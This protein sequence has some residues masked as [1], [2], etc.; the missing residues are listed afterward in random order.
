MSSGHGLD[1][2]APAEIASANLRVIRGL[3]DDDGVARDAALDLVWFDRAA[4]WAMIGTL[5]DAC[6]TD[7]ELCR[8]GAG[9]LEDLL[10][11]DEEVSVQGLQRF[12]SEHPKTVQALACV[13]GDARMQALVRE[14]LGSR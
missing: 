8:V 11:C 13:W 3:D 1:R 4:A 14:V 2:V 7:E 9:L 10:R 5:I 6:E 12:S